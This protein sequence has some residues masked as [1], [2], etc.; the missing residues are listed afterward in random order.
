MSLNI[1]KKCFGELYDPVKFLFELL[2]EKRIFP[3]D[4]KIARVTPVF[5]GSDPSKLRHYRRISVLPCFSKILE[6]I[7]CNHIYKYL[8]ENKI[9][10]PKKFGSQF[11]HS[12]DHAIIKF[13]DQRSEA[14]E[15]NLYTLCVF[16]SY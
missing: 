6:C 16:I 3:N 2:L 4:L 15:N 8:L 12:T 10:Y 14:F 7:M 11:G 13:L 1:A 9:F 5:E